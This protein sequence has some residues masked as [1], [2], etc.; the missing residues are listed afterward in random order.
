MEDEERQTDIDQAWHGLYFLLTGA[1]DLDEIDR[2]S[3]GKA[4]FGSD[5]TDEEMGIAYLTPGEVEDLSARLQYIEQDALKARDD[6]AMMNEHELY[7]FEREW[8]LE[9]KQY[10][11]DRFDELKRVFARASREREALVT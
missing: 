2:H 5:V 11:L 1:T 6:V 10:L 3:L 7:P 8:G 4:V 9:E